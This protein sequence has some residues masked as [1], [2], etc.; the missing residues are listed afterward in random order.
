MTKP[1]L[2]MPTAMAPGVDTQLSELFTITRLWLEEDQDAKISEIAGKVEA[3][4]T[5]FPYQLSG[6]LL[7]RLPQL[8]IVSSFGV[9]YDHNDVDAMAK[10]GIVLTNTP[11]VLSDEVA[12]ST[13]ALLL[14]TIRE[15]CLAEQYLRQGNWADGT[16]YPLTNASL[17]DRSLGIV[18]LGRIGKAIATRLEGFGRPISYC[19]RNKQPHISYRYYDNVTN[20]ARDVDTLI[21]ITPGGPDTHHLVD[22]AVLKALGPRGIL[23]NVARGSVVDQPALIKALKDKTIYAA[24]L[25]VFA[26]EPNVP[27]ELLSLPNSVLLPH[28]ASASH[29]TRGLMGQLVVDNLKAFLEGKPPLSPVVETPFSGW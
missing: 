16:P 15:L 26:D 4:A 22:A 6:E 23:I 21:L 14:M 27:D 8:K 28:V 19:G 24:G 7:T 5:T 11:D 17:Q 10:S 3:I 1:N 25:D 9:G 18:G 2:L 20:M 12:D 13:I 29:Y